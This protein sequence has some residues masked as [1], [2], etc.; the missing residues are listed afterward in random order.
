MKTNVCVWG[1]SFYCVHQHDPKITSFVSTCAI[2]FTQWGNS[3]RV[4][5]LHLR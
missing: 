4:C 3:K 1:T 5:V 2:G